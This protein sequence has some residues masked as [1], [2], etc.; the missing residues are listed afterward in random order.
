MFWPQKASRVILF[1]SDKPKIR[2]NRETPLFAIDVNAFRTT[3][4]R[5]RSAM[6]GAEFHGNK[7]CDGPT[8]IRGIEVSIH[9]FVFVSLFLF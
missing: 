1:G 3:N 5:S 2:E 7:H 9:C 4:F 6:R 8:R